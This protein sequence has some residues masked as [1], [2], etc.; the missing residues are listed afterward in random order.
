[1]EPIHIGLVSAVA[2]LVM[3]VGIVMAGRAKKLRR[4]CT[5]MTMGKV[6]GFEV[7][8]SSSTDEDGDET[9][10]V[11]HYPIFSY[12]AMG[13]NMVKRS[14]VGTGRPRFAVGREVSVYYNPTNPDEYY[15][16]EDGSA[17]NIGV[18]FVVFGL[19]IFVVLMG[20]LLFAE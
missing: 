3:I 12:T 18:W 14:R 20:V 4:N 15:V 11:S 16:L 19:F 8:E 13:R 1:M 6:E 7:D 10:S 2:V 9:V 5:A 17:K